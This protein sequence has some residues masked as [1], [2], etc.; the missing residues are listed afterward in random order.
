MNILVF[1]KQIP[2]VAEIK[3]DPESKRILREGVKLIINPFDKRAVEEAIRIKERDGSTVT[4]ISMGPPDAADVLNY[5]LRM[6]ADRA[7]LISDRKFA[8][9]DTLVTSQVLAD[10]VK[11]FKA[12]LVLM[13]K[14][15]LDGETSQVPPEVAELSGRNFK[16][17][18]SKIEA[19]DDPR[20]LK[21]EQD[22]ERG[23]STFSI[24]LPAV[25]SVSEKINRARFVKPEI[26]DMK[27]RIET[28]DS[29]KIGVH[30][31][32]SEDSPTVVE[33]TEILESRRSVEMLQDVDEAIN[34]IIEAS[35]GKHSGI[36]V[37]EVAMPELSG[38]RMVLGIATG[39]PETAREIASKMLEIAG[40]GR[41]RID[42]MGSIDPKKLEG[43]PCHSYRYMRGGTVSTISDYVSYY[44]RRNRP[45]FVVFPSNTDGREIAG[46]VAARLKLGLTADCVDLNMENS[47]LIQ[48]KPAFG[49][50]IVARITS[51]TDPPMATVRQGMFKEVRRKGPF[52]TIDVEDRDAGKIKLLDHTEVP[53]DYVPLSDSAVV[54][55]VGKGIARKERIPGFLE[56]A[57]KLGAGLG[58]TRPIIDFHFLPRQQQVGITGV[59]IS[60]DL[61]VAL[62]IS[63]SSNHVVGFRYA[64]KVLAVNTDRDAPIFKFSDYGL[65]ADAMEFMEKL[66]DR[67]GITLT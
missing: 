48:Y 17:S 45:A 60:P 9:S 23:I 1:V 54:L 27:D 28:W 6:G 56:V 34:M 30:V 26:P 35:S 22:N 10:I 3:F 46:T 37:Q 33:D 59:S 63:G 5:S 16:S 21:V 36:S 49:G 66:A 15:S 67:L 14:Y 57:A 44:I 43:M 2:D 11:Q 31:T 65:V 8:G 13:G 29:S 41:Y 39:D 25:L 52:E 51:R 18:V 62:G 55:C 38:T 12:D 19:G 61:Y 40:D 47:S 50:E 64:G 42:M 24:R 20:I 4:V 32:G 58:G 53:G 7:I